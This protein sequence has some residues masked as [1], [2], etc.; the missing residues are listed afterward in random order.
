[1]IIKKIYYKTIRLIID[2]F[3]AFFYIDNTTYSALFILKRISYLESKATTK[4]IPIEKQ[5]FF[6]F[7]NRMIIDAQ[8]AD[9][10]AKEGLYGA[11]YSITAI[12]LRSLS[13]YASLVSNKNRLNDFWNE[14]KDT[15]QVDRNFYD[16]FK[17]STI[18]TIAKGKF[19]KDAFDKSEF[20]KLL[21]GSCYAIRKYY[22]MKMTDNNGLRYP[23]LTFGKFHQ[24][25]KEN[26]ICSVVGAIILDF[27][28]IFFE[29]Y[30]KQNKK[31]YDDLL[32][33][34]YTIIKRVQIKTAQY[35]KELDMRERKRTAAKTPQSVSK[36]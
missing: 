29:E 7:A 33:Y 25:S 3:L 22:S 17:E 18:R 9:F 21:H 2:A 23:L 14:E 10:L 36:K 35:K 24:K 28:G 34:Y 27:L 6:I 11:G 15:Y 13:M 8:S 19:G 16:A 12:M 30:K 4:P 1:M 5:V 20:E 26:G 32:K 31:D